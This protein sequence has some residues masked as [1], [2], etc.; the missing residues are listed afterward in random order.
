M[1]RTIINC[2]ARLDN[3][4]ATNDLSELKSW[5]EEKAKAYNLEFL[6]AHL[7]DGVVWGKKLDDGRLATSNDIL[8]KMKPQDNI[9]VKAAYE[10]APELRLETLQQVRLFGKNAELLLWRDGDNK[11]RA[12]LIEDVTDAVNATWLQRFDEPQLLWGTHGIPANSDF[13]L[14]WEGSQGMHQIIPI[15]LD[16]D[17]ECK[18]VKSKEPKLR[19]RHYLSKEGEAHVVASR[20]VG[21][22]NINDE[23]VNHG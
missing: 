15:K 4:I 6:L 2:S 16:L 12:R 14:I 19:V 10:T 11:P 21:I 20:L 23:E 1:A 22:D 17:G 18:I 5:L 8:K 13:T 9:Q 3:D 7:D